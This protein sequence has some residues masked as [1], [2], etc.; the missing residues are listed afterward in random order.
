MSMGN[1]LGV[2]AVGLPVMAATNQPVAVNHVTVVPTN[3]E[4]ERCPECET[5]PC[6][7]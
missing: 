1:Y 2:G 5:E 6:E 3:F 7:C 4:T